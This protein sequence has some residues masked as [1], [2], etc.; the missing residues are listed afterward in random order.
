MA[1]L[2]GRTA[3]DLADQLLGDARN[4]SF[5]KL[6][7]NLYAI[8]GDNLEDPGKSYLS[9]DRVRLGASASL[10]F[11]ASDVLD[12]R[13]MSGTDGPQ[14][15][16]TTNFLGM[17]GVDSPLAGYYVD[18]VAHDA[19]QGEGI[20]AAFL[21]FFNHRLLTLLHV[22]WRKYRY[23]ARFRPRADDQFSRYIFS[24]IGLNDERLRGDTPIPWSRLLSYAGLIASRSRSPDIVAGIVA[25]CLDLKSVRIREFVHGYVSVPDHQRTKVGASNGVLGASFVVGVRVDT[26]STRF[27]IVIDDLTQR[28]FRDFLPDGVSYQ[29]LRRLIDFLM[30]D[31]LAYDIELGL[32]RSEVPSF[33]LDR[34]EGA[35]LGWTT[36]V[37]AAPPD[38]L[39]RVTIRGRA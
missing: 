29:P 11:P 8:H 34:S 16:V 1:H 7:E 9:L 13:R 22:G 18:A 20:K 17:H 3:R 14:Y 24:L 38:H 6:L 35:N 28:R 39:P 37:G 36:F 19:A 5:Y 10:G 2:E 33:S 4:Y 21:D 15:R 31:P 12:A 32:L 27:T 23:Y 26:R 25:H 30:R